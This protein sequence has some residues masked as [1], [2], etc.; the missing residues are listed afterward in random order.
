M[1][2]LLTAVALTALTALAFAV[3]PVA[4]ANAAT[5]NG[6]CVLSGT[7]G[8]S[9]A[10]GL[11]P[12]AS[13]FAFNGSGTCAGVDGNN[14]PYTGP[15]TATAS[16]SGSLACSVSTG[17]GSG[18]LTLGNGQSVNFNLTLVGKATEVDLVLTGKTSGA[19][20]AHA[21]FATNA[22]AAAGCASNSVSSLGFVVSAT[23]VN[24]S[25]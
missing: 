2:K 1:R 21:T 8:L 20:Y 5:F 6:T 18:T 23:A 19:G 3:A 16:G 9:P 13:T 4:S 10:I 14:T 24:L 7:A 22:G 11:T 25:G 17:S 12:I 15:A